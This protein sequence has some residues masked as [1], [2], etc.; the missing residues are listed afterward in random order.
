MGTQ[1]PVGLSFVGPRHLIIL[2]HYFITP[3]AC[4]DMLEKAL[5]RRRFKVPSAGM[6]HQPT[7]SC[8]Q[9]GSGKKN[10]KEFPKPKISPGTESSGKTPIDRSDAGLKPV[11]SCNICLF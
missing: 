7:W 5:A 6:L 8:T 11:P 3:R 10:T 4:L 9:Q 2:R 1:L